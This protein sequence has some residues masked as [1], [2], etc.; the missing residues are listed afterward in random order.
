MVCPVITIVNMDDDKFVACED[1]VKECSFTVNMPPGTYVGLYTGDAMNSHEFIVTVVEGLE[2]EGYGYDSFTFPLNQYHSIL[3]PRCSSTFAATLADGSSIPDG[4]NVDSTGR[5]YGSATTAQEATNVVINISSDIGDTSITLS[6]TVKEVTP[7]IGILAQTTANVMNPVETKEEFKNIYTKVINGEIGTFNSIFT[8]NDDYC[9]F[10][11]DCTTNIAGVDDESNSR[12]TIWTSQVKFRS[13]VIGFYLPLDSSIQTKCAMIINN[14]LNDITL[15]DPQNSYTF[16]KQL[17]SDNKYHDITFIIYSSSIKQQLSAFYT[18]SGNNFIPIQASYQIYPN[19]VQFYT[20]PSNN[21]IL[22]K[23]VAKTITPIVYGGYNNDGWDGSLP[24]YLTLN[25]IGQIIYTVKSDVTIPDGEQVYA[26]KPKENKASY[27]MYIDFKELK[28]EDLGKGLIGSYYKT[29]ATGCKYNTIAG[30]SSLKFKQYDEINSIIHNTEGSDTW[31]GLTFELNNN[32][33]VKWSGYINIATEGTYEFKII[34]NDG[35]R[36]KID[37]NKLITETCGSSSTTKSMHLA[38]GLHPIT[39]EYWKSNNDY[40]KIFDLQY[41]CSSCEEGSDFGPI[42][43]DMFYYTHPSKLYYK[44]RVGSYVTNIQMLNKGIFATTISKKYNKYEVSP[45]YYSFTFAGADLEKIPEDPIEWTLFTVTATSID[46]DTYPTLTT[47]FEIEVKKY[48]VPIFSYNENNINKKLG[49]EV[50]LKATFTSGSESA[51]FNVES[52]NL[53][54]GLKLDIETGNIKGRVVEVMNNR[55]VTIRV[56]NPSGYRDVKLIFTVTGCEENSHFFYITY[57]P[58]D[59]NLQLKLKSTE[60]EEIIYQN[61]DDQEVNKEYFYSFCKAYTSV[62]VDMVYSGHLHGDFGIYGEKNILFHYGYYNDNDYK[63][64]I[65]QI[66]IDKDANPAIQYPDLSKYEFVIGKPILIIPIKYTAITGIRNNNATDLPNGVTMNM[67]TGVISGKS[68]ITITNRVYQI[69]PE[70]GEKDGA[71]ISLSITI[72]DKCSVGELY[73]LSLHSGKTKGDIMTFRINDGLT[74]LYNYKGFPNNYD[75]EWGFCYDNEI[76]VINYGGESVW[77]SES[78]IVLTNVDKNDKRTYKYTSVVE[79]GMKSDVF[80]SYK[81]SIDATTTVWQRSTVYDKNWLY[82][83]NMDDNWSE[84][85]LINDTKTTTTTT[86][87]YRTSFINASPST[88]NYLLASFNTTMQG[89]AFYLNGNFIYKVNLPDDFTPETPPSVPGNTAFKFYIP[90]FLQSANNVNIFAIEYHRYMNFGISAFTLQPF[91]GSETCVTPDLKNFRINGNLALTNLTDGDLTTYEKFENDNIVSENNPVE[92]IMK[93]ASEGHSFLSYSISTRKYETG[94]CNS[95]IPK[96]WKVYGSISQD[97]KWI[98]LDEVDTTMESGKT[99]YFTTK[100]KATTSY[101]GIKVVIT[102]TLAK[103]SDEDSSCGYGVELSEFN[104]RYCT[105]SQCTTGSYTPSNIGSFYKYPCPNGDGSDSVIVKCDLDGKWEDED[106]SQCKIAVSI[107]YPSSEYTFT[108]GLAITPI[109]PTINGQFNNLVFE[110]LLPNGIQFN[111]SNGEISGTPLYALEQGQTFTIRVITDN[112]ATQPSTQLT[113]KIVTTNCEAEG[114][115]PKSPV[116]TIHRDYCENDKSGYR[117]ITCEMKDSKPQWGSWNVD[118]CVDKIRPKCTVEEEYVYKIKES[119]NIDFSCSPAVTEATIIPSLPLGLTLSK[120]GKLTGIAE[121]AQNAEYSITLKTA[122]GGFDS[123]TLK[124]RVWDVLTRCYYPF[125]DNKIK[126]VLNQKIELLPPK[127]NTEVGSYDITGLPNGVSYD[128]DTGIIHGKPTTKTSGTI[129]TKAKNGNSETADA[130]IDYEIVDINTDVYNNQLIG[131]YSKSNYISDLPNTFEPFWS[132]FDT[133]SSS[134]SSSNSFSYEEG[135]SPENVFSNLDLESDKQTFQPN[136]E[137]TYNYFIKWYGFVKFAQTGSYYIKIESE[138]RVWLFINNMSTP[139]VSTTSNTAESNVYVSKTA[140]EIGDSYIQ[141]GVMYYHAQG[142]SFQ[143]RISYSTDKTTYS[144][145]ED[146][147]LY[148]VANPLQTLKYPQTHY[149]FRQ[150]ENSIEEIKPTIDSTIIA[151][152]ITPSLSNGLEFNEKTGVISGSPNKGKV[153][154]EPT[155]YVVTIESKLNSISVDIY[156]DVLEDKIGNYQKGVNAKYYLISDSKC[157]TIPTGSSSTIERIESKLAHSVDAD[158]Y[159][160]GYSYLTNFLVEFDGSINIETATEGGN[161]FTLESYDSAV[162]YID[163]EEV[164]KSLQCGDHTVKDV[165]YELSVGIHKIQVKY[166]KSSTDNF[167][168]I[169]LKMN[170]EEPQIYNFLGSYMKYTVRKSEYISGKEI[171]SFSPLF[172]NSATKNQFKAFSINPPFTYSGITGLLFNSETGEISGTPVV[173]TTGTSKEFTITAKDESSSKQENSITDSIKLT[174]NIVLAPSDL[175]YDDITVSVGETISIF[176]KTIINGNGVRYSVTSDVKLPE[177]IYLNPLTGEISGYSSISFIGKVEITASNDAGSTKA[178]VNFKID[179]CNVLSETNVEVKLFINGGSDI[180]FGFG[181]STIDY[182]FSEDGLKLNTLYEY[183]KCIEYGVNFLVLEGNNIYGWY[184]IYSDNDLLKY[185]EV[186]GSSS[187]ETSVE[188]NDSGVPSV[189]YENTNIIQSQSFKFIPTIINGIKKIEIKNLPTEI[190][191]NETSGIISGTVN[192]LM[193]ELMF[194]MSYTNSKGVMSYGMIKFTFEVVDTVRNSIVKATITTKSNGND[195]IIRILKSSD[196]SIEVEWKNLG[197]NS[198]VIKTELI[199]KDLYMLELSSGTMASWSAGSSV[200]LEMDGT[201]VVTNAYFEGNS[202]KTIKLSSDASSFITSYT[203]WEYKSDNTQPPA[204]WYKSENT[205]WNTYAPGSFPKRTYVTSYYKT[206]FYYY[207]NDNSKVFIYGELKVDFDDGIVIYVN[208]NEIYRK[209]ILKDGVTKDT[210]AYYQFKEVVTYVMKINPNLI[211]SGN[212]IVAVELH[213][214]DDS[215]K[216]NKFK[217][218]L[219]ATS[220]A[221]DTITQITPISVGRTTEMRYEYDASKIDYP[222]K[223]K[224]CKADYL[225]QACVNSHDNTGMSV[226]AVQISD[227]E[228]DKVKAVGVYFTHKLKQTAGIFPFELTY[229]FKENVANSFNYMYYYPY[230]NGEQFSPAVFKIYGS[231]DY[232]EDDKTHNDDKWDLLFSYNNKAIPTAQSVTHTFTFDNL[233]SYEAY[234]LYVEDT[235][236][237]KNWV[238]FNEMQMRLTAQ[239]YCVADDNHKDYPKTSAGETVEFSCPNPKQQ[240]SIKISC[241]SDGKWDDENAVDTCFIPTTDK[242]YYSKDNTITFY[243]DFTS[244]ISPSAPISGTFSK[245]CTLPVGLSFDNS[246]GLIYGKPNAIETEQISVTCNIEVSGQYSSVVIINVVQLYCA[247]IGEYEKAKAG[248]TNKKGCGDLYNGEKYR[249]CPLQLSPVYEDEVN[250]CD[251]YPPLLSYPESKY[252]II[253][254]AVVDIKPITGGLIK[255]WSIKEESELPNGIKFENG[256][257]SGTATETIDMTTFTITAKNEKYENSTQISIQVLFSIPKT[258]IFNAENTVYTNVEIKIKPTLDDEKAGFLKCESNP[259]LPTGLKIDQNT[260]VISGIVTDNNLIGE[261]SYVVTGSVNEKTLNSNSFTIEIKKGE[262]IKIEEG[263][264]PIHVDVGK[265]LQEARCTDDQKGYKAFECLAENPPV[266]GDEIDKCTYKYPSSFSYNKNTIDTTMYN[267]V[268]LKPV[269]GGSSEGV[270]T[271]TVF[272]LSSDSLLPKDLSFDKDTGVINGTLNEYIET[273][274]IITISVNN[275]IERTTTISFKVD[276]AYCPAIEGVV[277]KTKV[278]DLPKEIACP[279]PQTGNIVYSCKKENE[280]TIDKSKCLDPDVGT[281]TYNPPDLVFNVG[282]Y[283]QFK[284]TIYGYTTDIKIIDTLPKGIYINATDGTI[285]GTPEVELAKQNINV[286][287]Y[288]KTANKTTPITITVIQLYCEEEGWDKTKTGAKAVKECPS[289]SSYGENY[290]NCPMERPDPKFDDEVNTCHTPYPESVDY[291]GDNIIHVVYN[292]EFTQEV[293]IKGNTPVDVTFSLDEDTK[294]PDDIELNLKDGSIYGTLNTKLEPGMDDSKV[295]KICCNGDVTICV[296]VKLDVSYTDCPKDDNYDATKPGEVVERDCT[297][298]RPNKETRQC[299]KYG[300][301]ENPDTSKCIYP[302]PEISY[303]KSDIKVYVDEEIEENKI[304]IVGKEITSFVISPKDKLNGLVFDEVTGV[305][306]GKPTLPINQVFTIYC[307]NEGGKSNEVQII[308]KALYRKPSGIYYGES[309]TDTKPLQFKVKLTQEY[310]IKQESGGIPSSYSITDEKRLNGYGILFDTRTGRIYT[311]NNLNPPKVFENIDPF[312]VTAKNEDGSDTVV[313]NIE[314]IIPKCSAEDGDGFPETSPGETAKIKCS[315]DVDAYEYR[316]CSEDGKWETKNTYDC[317]YNKPEKCLYKTQNDFIIDPFATD[318]S[319]NKINME[320][321]SLDTRVNSIT[322]SLT[323]CKTEL[324]AIGL[325][326]DENDGIF[327]GSPTAQKLKILCRAVA[328]NDKG[329]KTSNDFYISVYYKAPTVMTYN[330]NSFIFYT[331]LEIKPVEGSVIKLDSIVTLDYTLKSADQTSLLSNRGLSLNKTSGFIIGTPNS[332]TL[333]ETVIYVN[334][335]NEKGSATGNFTITIISPNCPK[336]GE[337]PITPANKVE[338]LECIEGYTDRFRKRECLKNGTWGEIDSSDCFDKVVTSLHYNPSSISLYVGNE[339]VMNKPTY[340]GKVVE[341]AIT[342]LGVLEKVGLKWNKT[343]GI[344]YGSPTEELAKAEYDV[345]AINNGGISEP[346]TITI[347]VEKEPARL[348]V[349]IPNTYVWSRNGNETVTT[350]VPY[351]IGNPIDFSISS[352]SVITACGLSF[353]QWTGQISGMPK[354]VLVTQ[355]F[356][357]TA[358]NAEGTNPTTTITLTIRSGDILKCNKIDDDWPEATGGDVLYNPC[359]LVSSDRNRGIISRK[360]LSSGV[361]DSIDESLCKKIDKDHPDRD[362]LH[363]AFSFIVYD[364]DIKNVKETEYKIL[365]EK[366]LNAFG[367]FRNDD[368]M[369][370]E[371]IIRKYQDSRLLKEKLS[372]DS[373]TTEGVI[374]DSVVKIKDHGNDTDEAIDFFKSTFTQSYIDKNILRSQSSEL[375]LGS[376]SKDITFEEVHRHISDDDDDND[377]KTDILVIIIP[378][379]CVVVVIIIII[380]S[381]L[382]WKARSRKRA[383]STAGSADYRTHLPSVSFSESRTRGMSTS[384]QVAM[385][386]NG[387]RS[388]GMSIANQAK[389]TSKKVRV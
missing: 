248:S 278:N 217:L 211:V 301:W 298:G 352:I 257:F 237:N 32:I 17:T 195:M 338:S 332:L 341:F 202:V 42:T 160:V 378:I 143:L 328:A 273:E 34:A 48:D 150:S 101:E 168:K 366:I 29:T 80:S 77:D 196:N 104:I 388:R 205:N 199:K 236:S 132:L 340:Y 18:D 249:V 380:V 120:D 284:P 146:S 375:L 53:P 349:V 381:V 270:T 138:E 116:G 66:D 238:Q 299:T 254:D 250:T 303:E 259:L 331:N 261:S 317:A 374:F 267:Y 153:T 14:D 162:V 291:N 233:K 206:S 65:N 353:D 8:K 95:L 245:D 228:G 283:N 19:P 227:C 50:D 103:S 310:N 365:Q 158:W 201:T 320:K 350:A 209:N 368:E 309:V 41:K 151:A 362:Y 123:I 314:I 336:D 56:I 268:E 12:Y 334:G 96:K 256:I 345:T 92:L 212:N 204:D 315:N 21:E 252:Y 28:T 178:T 224:N 200:T 78:E 87:Y 106:Y 346:F 133:E 281:V 190:S 208:G 279:H 176:P 187:V 339:V 275:E 251:P 113:I 276:Y 373:K 33:Y 36:L 389:H 351:V 141:I 333:D 97:T 322:I 226:G 203:K 177:G 218:E 359:S 127:C 47:T 296:D 128:E 175:S 1:A 118:N 293:T 311:S 292:Q 207:D 107:Y 186:Q 88:V 182:T 71:I 287:V 157:G 134:S 269:L 194:D 215:E 55:D 260:C 137:R 239:K 330:P 235:K 197:D 5:I 51:L 282:F 89:A 307:Q 300:E 222:D 79:G 295:Y 171:K 129:T 326:W 39:I 73:V 145:I 384:S 387:G 85:N 355:S 234:K 337:W 169:I 379:V 265:E 347:T 335:N 91:S 170:G 155:K 167:R 240:G 121:T 119:V 383:R 74:T 105:L 327:T 216:E 220:G 325:V 369:S 25:D 210:K 110:P 277:D 164:I 52:N 139:V 385:N 159:D 16:V 361:W 124:M 294:L 290:R 360:C 371:T 72:V 372:K 318:T 344:L 35:G 229:I 172:L 370:V 357:L 24:D 149:L 376:S 135:Y 185:E 386:S 163:D 70:N 358:N 274:R 64:S 231:T 173:T 181:P 189:S 40:K 377:N 312:T 272:T 122:D 263:K 191:L 30:S 26:I 60:G 285:Y 161:T 223:F 286:Y 154:T 59:T 62:I 302:A 280:W 131:L 37:E 329:V 241:K 221:T 214:K 93:T 111:P 15:S 3:P 84:V 69:K 297:N 61:T 10:T 324:E 354:E 188:T 289:D 13:D 67:K 356:T 83:M 193:S 306:S 364:L 156:I 117:T 126:F 367:A 323:S 112:S 38:A 304:T 130:A 82:N 109:K 308:I 174:I 148:H 313:V 49:E 225:H 81:T 2:C 348:L 86:T 58:I 382:V 288:Y 45:S 219:S 22:Y 183:K 75:Y 147:M 180:R 244:S 57:T 100:T 262:C 319:V 258:M 192:G 31:N 11:E 253:K 266:F 316:K 343:E 152:S 9:K 243:V 166:W 115:I 54:I 27:N 165:K 125:T 246:N 264:D 136:I 63:Q 98:E 20:Y 144:P 232:N 142:K 271:P 321:P 46:A 94:S 114:S 255:E 363:L 247:G 213:N 102:E 230:T 140:I 184:E 7:N 6:I 179:G 68:S 242:I 43:S 76:L 99:Y 4:L 342:N 23:S 305:L 198:V 108:V 44:N 90:A